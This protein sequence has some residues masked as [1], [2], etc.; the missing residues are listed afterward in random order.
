MV[1]VDV[2]LGQRYR[3]YHKQSLL[4]RTIRLGLR[5]TDDIEK[6]AQ[7]FSESF[8]LEMAQ[9]IKLKHH[10]ASVLRNYEKQDMSK[11]V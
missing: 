1:Y 5:K 2:N 8:G 6:V 7:A 11:T 10:I 9:M 3:L 4:F